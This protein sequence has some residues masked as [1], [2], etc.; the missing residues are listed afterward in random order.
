V[1]GRA[2]FR[3]EST[4]DEDAPDGAYPQRRVGLP[5]ALRLTRGYRRRIGAGLLLG[6]AGAGL[7]LAQPLLAMRAIEAT[8]AGTSVAAIVAL[9]ALVFVAEALVD[10]TA[11]Y[12]LQRT[13][14]NIVFGLRRRLVDRMLRLVMP[15]YDRHRTGDLMSRVTT[16]TGML[17]N[18]VAFDLVDA[19]TGS[20][21]V[22]GGVAL[23]IWLDPVLFALVGVT[24][25]VGGLAVLGALSGIRTATQRAQDDT[26]AMISDLERALSAIRTVRACRAEE[27]EAL[28]ISGLAG[29]VCAANIRA[30]KLDSVVAPAVGLAAHGS[31]ILV[32]VIGG[33]R[34]ASGAI[35]L[36]ELV[37]FLLYVMYIAMPM[38]D[39]FGLAGTV[40][41]A[42]AALQ[43]VQYAMDLPVEVEPT[44]ASRASKESAT[45]APRGGVASGNGDAR[46]HPALEFVDVRFGYQSDR[47]VLDGVSF[48]VPRGA[49]VALVGPS[50][51]GKSTIFALIS[52][53]YEP[54]HG[55]IRLDGRDVR[56][57]LSIAQC[58]G[59]I[60]LV[61]Q[62]TPVLYGT[63]RDNL[64]YAHPDASEADVWR[65]VDLANLRELVDRL[66]RRLETDVGE[67][68]SLLSGGERQRLAIAR[69]LLGRPSLLL[70][71][72]PT[73]Q[74]DAAN[75][76]A[77][78]RTIAAVRGECSLLV[79]AHRPATVRT[80]DVVIALNG[81]RV[82]ATDT[83]Q[84]V[85]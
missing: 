37:A 69:A 54:Q 45:I 56:T 73:S 5:D 65:A 48:E 84:Y 15:V 14:E 60:G 32:L 68:G 80:A 28:R 17:R 25:A 66:P 67:R 11:R 76:A 57:E 44:P 34:V 26:G 62:H 63:L 72:E 70:L 21:V 43:R 40:Q 13:S 33:T 61:E 7:G 78:A 59:R 10:A 53:F 71:D 30:A 9:L 12:V 79:I 49:H 83:H 36:G 58:R 19:L 6:L 18:V 3:P 2:L 42:L 16:D 74:L 39:L 8:G 55:V 75:E 77:L 81:G 22:I 85:S 47:P 35:T 51:A 20:F 31:L 41:R 46:A 24:V 50:G 29:S 64:C 27:R 4:D 1:I 23:M 38:A 52:R 82:A